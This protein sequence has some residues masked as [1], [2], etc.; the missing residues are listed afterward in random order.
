VRVTPIE[1]LFFAAQ[2]RNLDLMRC[3]VNELGANV[4]QA[5]ASGATALHIAAITAQ[6]DQLHAICCLVPEYGAIMT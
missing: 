5:D 6:D 2:D 3:L 4:N 1:P